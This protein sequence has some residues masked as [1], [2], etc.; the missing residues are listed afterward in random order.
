MREVG[1]W[2]EAVDLTEEDDVKR[3]NADKKLDPQKFKSVLGMA[4]TSESIKKYLFADNVWL[5]A[6]AESLELKAPKQKTIEADDP[7]PSAQTKKD[8]PRDDFNMPLSFW[9][10]LGGVFF[11]G[12]KKHTAEALLLKLPKKADQAI[13]SE[14]GHEYYSYDALAAYKGE[15][16]N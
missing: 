10:N 13:L 6:R 15:A 12:Q 9:C 16:G 5:I 1:G 4:H 7:G 11:K 14:Y 8:R 3:W 2:E